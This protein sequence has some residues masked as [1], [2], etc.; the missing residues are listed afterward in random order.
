MPEGLQEAFLRQSYS[1]SHL[2]VH[3]STSE[4][5]NLTESPIESPRL[6]TI[7]RPSEMVHDAAAA[8]EQKER[9]SPGD[10]WNRIVD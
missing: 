5:T 2:L 8:N 9:R 1:K 7:A 3:C 10:E 4:K 6:A